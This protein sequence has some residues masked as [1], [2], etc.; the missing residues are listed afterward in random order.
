METLYLGHCVLVFQPTNFLLLLLV[1][2]SKSAMKAE[3]K[4]VDPLD[5]QEQL[6]EVVG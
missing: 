2:L 6:L 1:N 3:A 5:T 4:S